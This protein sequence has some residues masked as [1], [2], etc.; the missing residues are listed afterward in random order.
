MNQPFDATLEEKRKS[1]LLLQAAVIRDSGDMEQA[2]TLFAAAAEIEELLAREAD[3]RQDDM[4]AL[5][6]WYSAASAWAYAGDFY[7][8][9]TLLRTLEGRP[10]V[11][12]ALRDRIHAFSEKVQEQ[13]EHWRE[14]LLELTSSPV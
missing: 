12:V 11:P 7:H 13:R 3:A 8:A 1:N 9:L 14:T 6:A 4:H 5:R 2:S 10:G